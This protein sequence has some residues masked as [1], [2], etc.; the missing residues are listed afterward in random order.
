[1]LVVD[2]GPGLSGSSFLAAAEAVRDAG[3]AP[4]RIHLLGTRAVDPARLV[5]PEGARRWAAFTAHVA[6]GPRPWHRADELDLSGGAWR[7][8]LN[9]RHHGPRG[10]DKPPVWPT[11]ERLKGLSLAEPGASI[12]RKF[13]GLPPLGH[14]VFARADV[15]SAAG[16]C[17]PLAG[18]LDV[19]GFIPH[20][21]IPGRPLARRQ[22]TPA[23]A[24]HIGRYIALRAA[25]LP[26]PAPTAAERAAFQTMIETNV[27]LELGRRFDLG[28]PLPVPRPT[29][30][31]GRLGPHEWIEDVNGRLWKTDACDHGDD[32]FFPGPTDVAWDLA[33]AIVEWDLEG[34]AR[35]QLLTAYSACAGE[36]PRGR[37]RGY[38][39]GYTA[40]RARLSLIAAAS[41]DEED[42]AL[43]QRAHADHARQLRLALRDF[44]AKDTRRLC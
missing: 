4:A 2:E 24:E 38:L 27:G 16:L 8:H 31:D 43:W 37:L 7:T 22:M 40:F 33:G 12:L 19:D 1:V 28:A 41:C 44:G 29:I 18:P 10:A 36:N 21:F 32:H 30:A 34:P 3:I 20:R 17:P 11:S 26:A 15:M 25:L 13:A 23:V 6:P 42:A 39:V 9:H 5:A 35:E 14:A